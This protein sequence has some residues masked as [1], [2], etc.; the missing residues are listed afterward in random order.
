MTGGI[1]AE[2][3]MIMIHFLCQDVLW[4]AYDTMIP[5]HSC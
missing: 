2:E 1:E 4:R 3:E 5:F